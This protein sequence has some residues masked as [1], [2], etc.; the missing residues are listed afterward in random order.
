M[1]KVDMMQTTDTGQEADFTVGLTDQGTLWIVAGDRESAKALGV[2]RKPVRGAGG[3]RVYPS[4]PKAYLD[5]LRFQFTGS[6]IRATEPY[7]G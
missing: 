6:R 1:L 2:P 4:D 7:E 5:A 3:R